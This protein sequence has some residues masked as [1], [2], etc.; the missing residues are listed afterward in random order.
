MELREPMSY[1][2][3]KCGKV[4]DV[5]PKWC[6]CEPYPAMQDR[7]WL[8]DKAVGG[9]TEISEKDFLAVVR[10]MF[11]RKVLGTDWPETHEQALRSD[12]V[13]DTGYSIVRMIDDVT[14]DSEVTEDSFPEIR[15]PLTKEEYESALGKLGH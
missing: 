9:R 11:E 10:D 6:P 13:E 15:V 8:E 14:V 12:G 2:C 5:P 1:K 7:F 4:Y 3:P